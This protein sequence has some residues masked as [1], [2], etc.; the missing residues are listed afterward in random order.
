M[1]SSLVSIIIPCYNAA[2]YVEEAIQSALN[3][4]YCNT[5]VIVIDDGSTDGSLQAIQSFGNA[6]RW[7]TGPNRGGCVARN[8]GI[9]LARGEFIQFLDADDV[10]F[11][12]KLEVQVPISCAHFGRVVYCDHIAV[13]EDSE[14]ESEI[15][16][17]ALDE[18]DPVVFVLHHKTLQTSAPLY[19]REWL[20]AIGGFR[21]GLRASQEF[22]LNLRFAAWGGL[23]WLHLPE[24][25]FKVRRRS[26]SVSSNTGRALACLV[27]VLPAFHQDLMRRGRLSE[28]R[29]QEI[30]RYTA[31]VARLCAREGERAA[32]LRLLE[33]AEQVDRSSA[34]RSAYSLPSRIVRELVGASAVEYLAETRKKMRLGLRQ[35][36]SNK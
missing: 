20:T 3:Q 22:D 26:D 4:T 33:F 11:S 34:L 25:L 23:R 14:R 21:P 24:V 16:S 30:A 19:R 28:E 13:W 7:E 18:P 29:R 5:E 6:I 31:S 9:E 36:T 35:L 12:R 10:L 2:P 17:T 27:D 8:L 32:G 1:T 15:R